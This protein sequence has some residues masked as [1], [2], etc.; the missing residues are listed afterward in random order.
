MDEDHLSIYVVMILTGYPASTPTT[1][2]DE[3]AIT[4]L[5]AMKKNV[6]RVSKPYSGTTLVYPITI[7][8]K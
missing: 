5:L 2:A 6:S 3:A 8:P 1:A 7:P 4:V